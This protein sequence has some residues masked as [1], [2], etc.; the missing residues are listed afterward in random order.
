MERLTLDRL[1]AMGPAVEEAVAF[2]CEGLTDPDPKRK[3]AVKTLWLAA[4]T[5][6][7]YLRHLAEGG[8]PAPEGE[9]QFPFLWEQVYRRLEPLYE[10]PI[11]PFAALLQLPEEWDHPEAWSVGE[12]ED[13]MEAFATAY[14][15]L[16]PYIR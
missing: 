6:T 2:L 1:R 12:I 10:G 4:N 16:L 9:Q 5:T 15:R 14:S 13:A 7:A 11:D 8:S 3:I